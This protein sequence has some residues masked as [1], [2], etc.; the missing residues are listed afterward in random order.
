MDEFALSFTFHRVLLAL[1]SRLPAESDATCFE[2]QQSIASFA[3]TKYASALRASTLLSDRDPAISFRKL[4][5]RAL[6]FSPPLS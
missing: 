4:F 5:M 3:Q 2:L 1:D 6:I